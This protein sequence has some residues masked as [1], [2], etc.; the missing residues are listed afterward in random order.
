LGWLLVGG[1]VRLL[2]D[3]TAGLLRLELGQRCLLFGV[4]LVADGAQQ[5]DGFFPDA[6]L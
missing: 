3:F 1:L 6:L 4:R 2:L 5:I